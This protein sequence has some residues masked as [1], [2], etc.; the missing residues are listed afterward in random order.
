MVLGF[1]EATGNQIH[2]R[3]LRTYV[4]TV[5]TSIQLT[6]STGEVIETT[7]RQRFLTDA[8]DGIEAGKTT[9]GVR[10]KTPDG[11]TVE[12]TSV[13]QSHKLMQVHS[14]LLANGQHFL[15]GRTGIH[16]FHNKE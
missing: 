6:L 3:V 4:Q 5:S 13:S 15:V 9:P 2:R 12:V 8:G 1:D 10:L 14:M 7:P 11:A 16:A